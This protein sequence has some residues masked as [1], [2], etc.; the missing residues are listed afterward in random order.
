MQKIV[1]ATL[2]C[3][4]FYADWTIIENICFKK[5]NSQNVTHCALFFLTY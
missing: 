2:Q 1:K 3:K 4:Y 5:K